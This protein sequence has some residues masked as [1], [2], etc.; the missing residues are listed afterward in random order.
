MKTY[1][2]GIRLVSLGEVSVEVLAHRVCLSFLL[3]PSP[4]GVRIFNHAAQIARHL[5]VPKG[6]RFYTPQRETDFAGFDFKD[7]KT[8]IGHIPSIL[9]WLAGVGQGVPT[10]LLAPRYSGTS[11]IAD[12]SGAI[13]FITVSFAG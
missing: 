5:S 8:R 3:D 7:Q 13:G 9:Q 11:L 10:N 2:N 4:Q 12:L 6:I 1:H